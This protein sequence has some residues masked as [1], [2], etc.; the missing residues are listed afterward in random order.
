MPLKPIPIPNEA[1]L[2][3]IIMG[4]PWAIEEGL[5]VLSHQEITR[6]GPLDLLCVDTDERLVVVEL[7]IVEDN[8]MLLQ[9]FRYYDYINENRDAIIRKFPE[10]NIKSEI[11]RVALVA[12]SFSEELKTAAKYITDP[13]VELFVF[14]YFEVESGRHDIF[15]E[16]VEI[17]APSV[18]VE[19]KTMD[20]LISYIRQEPVRELCLSVIEKIKSLGK[21]IR[22]KATQFYIGLLY[23]NRLVSRIQCFREYFDVH[24]PGEEMSGRWEDWEVVR[25]GSKDDMRQLPFDKIE[26]GYVELGGKTSPK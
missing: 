17:R 26:D 7:K 11:P 18:P 20:D 10:E 24:Y 21:G 1:T 12:P 22:P 23:K 4:H 16:P 6:T 8:D 13:K 5:R 19:S 2:E 25:I 14:R 15:L 9:A 3:E